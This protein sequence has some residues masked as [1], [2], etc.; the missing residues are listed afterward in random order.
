MSLS[1][2]ELVL[3]DFDG[4]LIDSIPYI[5]RC[6]NKSLADM[7]QPKCELDHIRQW[8]GNG[9][10]K[11]LHRA[12]TD[13]IDGKADAE[14]INE[15]LERFRRYYLAQPCELTDCY[16]GVRDGLE[17]LKDANMTLGIVTNKNEEFV[18]PLLKKFG[19]NT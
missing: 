14:L 1:R 19:I 6:V 12:L 13:D 5:A 10:E 7:K 4:T 3:L 8:V 16:P 18:P 2:P 9:V 11:L 15:A 17:Q